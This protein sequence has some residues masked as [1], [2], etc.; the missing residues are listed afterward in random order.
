VVATARAAG[1]A[2]LMFL[3]P[4]SVFMVCPLVSS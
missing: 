2:P 3:T 1:H 4:F